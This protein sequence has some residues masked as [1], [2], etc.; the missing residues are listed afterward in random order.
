MAWRDVLKSSL[1]TRTNHDLQIRE[2][3]QPVFGM[4]GRKRLL[5]HPSF[6]KH[7]PW[8]R[9]KSSQIMA[10]DLREYWTPLEFHVISRKLVSGSTSLSGVMSKKPV[11]K[12][13]ID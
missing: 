8:H 10:L 12:Q 4:F 6:H 9:K 5:H 7:Y 2:T 3:D 1:M 13:S 11:Q